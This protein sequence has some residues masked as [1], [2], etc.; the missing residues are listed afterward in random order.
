M[1]I[2]NDKETKKPYQWNFNPPTSL[3]I[4]IHGEVRKFYFLSP[5]D[6]NVSK[7]IRLPRTNPKGLK[8]YKV[9]HDCSL[10]NYSLLPFSLSVLPGAIKG[11]CSKSE[12]GDGSR[13]TPVRVSSPLNLPLRILLP[14]QF[15]S[16]NM[17]IW[18]WPTQLWLLPHLVTLSPLGLPLLDLKFPLIPISLAVNLLTARQYSCKTQKAWQKSSRRIQAACVYMI[19]FHWV[20]YHQGTNQQFKFYLRTSSFGIAWLPSAWANTFSVL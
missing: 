17:E 20:L 3:F 9:P 5:G 12:N 4:A 11:R 19:T 16:S 13:A 8:E 14:I 18:L 7:Y 6:A 10:C 15:T 1:K 2:D